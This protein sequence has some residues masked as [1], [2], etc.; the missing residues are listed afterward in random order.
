MSMKYFYDNAQGQFVFPSLDAINFEIN[1]VP[2][3]GVTGSTGG[4]LTSLTCSDGSITIGSTAGGYI[5]SNAGANVGSTNLNMRNNAIT[6]VNNIN[7]GSFNISSS[8]VLQIQ[9]GNLPVGEVFDSQYNPPTFSDFVGNGQTMNFNNAIFEN[10]LTATIDNL[11]VNSSINGSAFD[12]LIGVT[13]PAG[14]MGPTGPAGPSGND[15]NSTLEDVVNNQPTDTVVNFP[16]NVTLQNI[17]QLTFIDGL[18]QGTI[19]GSNGILGVSGSVSASDYLIDG[20]SIVVPQ[21]TKVLQFHSDIFPSGDSALLIGGNAS[22]TLIKTFTIPNNVNYVKCTY[23]FII[24]SLDINGSGVSPPYYKSYSFYIGSSQIND[25][26][27]LYT[28]EGQHV[29]IYSSANDVYSMKGTCTTFIQS[30]SYD[31]LSLYVYDNVSSFSGNPSVQSISTSFGTGS[32]MECIL[33]FDH[34]NPAN[35]TSSIG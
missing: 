6:N 18:V 29:I 14:P 20:Q 26:S 33:E 12:N 1:N 32:Q 30:G 2:V 17:Q 11:V 31:S 7:V 3:S 28:M 4:T 34:L 35:V 19:A 15:A 13:G 9:N 8:G 23:D 25:D 24:E 10:V 16:S 22:A 21:N 27:N 5:L